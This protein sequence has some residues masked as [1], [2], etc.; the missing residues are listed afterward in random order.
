MAAYCI[1][2]LSVYYVFL[3]Y[4]DTVGWFFWPVKTVSNMTYTVLAGTWN[5]AQSINQCF[6]LSFSY[7][8]LP[9]Y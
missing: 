3:E 7:T 4:F 5:T 6:M 9:L 2:E 8:V 1:I